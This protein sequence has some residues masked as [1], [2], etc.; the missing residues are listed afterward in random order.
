MELKIETL[1]TAY[2]YIE[3][4]KSGIEDLVDRYREGN[5]TSELFLDVIEGLRWII[6]VMSLTK[7]IQVGEIDD[8]QLKEKVR[9]ML[10]ALENKDNNLLADLFEYEVVEILEMYQ[11]VIKSTLE[12]N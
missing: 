3:N 9:E 11:K 12:S 7:D 2:E 6:E 5:E 4:L 1:Q 8:N 10:Q